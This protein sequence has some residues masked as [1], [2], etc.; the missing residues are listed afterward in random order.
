MHPV[1]GSKHTEAAESDSEFIY[2]F[3]EQ[4]KPTTPLRPVSNCLL[5]LRLQDSISRKSSSFKSIETIIRKMDY[6]PGI[7]SEEL[8]QPIPPRNPAVE[9]EQ[10]K[11]RI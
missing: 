3:F 6:A 10:R 11:L 2:L 5:Q 9:L 7:A 8:A 1:S 4:R